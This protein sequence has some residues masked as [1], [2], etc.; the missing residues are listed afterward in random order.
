VDA[1]GKTVEFMLSA[2]RDVSEVKR[3]FNK[4]MRAEQRYL[5]LSIS[6]DKNAGYPAATEPQ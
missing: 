3:F 2:K 6:V 1:E 5:P 4:M